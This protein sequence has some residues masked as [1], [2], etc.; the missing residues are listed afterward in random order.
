MV[1]T[2]INLFEKDREI[3]SKVSS[4]EKTEQAGDNYVSQLQRLIEQRINLIS[5]FDDYVANVSK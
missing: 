4:S 3:L 5:T 2:Y 1:T